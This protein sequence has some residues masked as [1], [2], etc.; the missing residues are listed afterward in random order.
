MKEGSSKKEAQAKKQLSRLLKSFSI[1]GVLNLLSDLFEEASRQAEA[2]NDRH[3]RDRCDEVRVAL[4]VLG[5]GADAVCAPA[6][7]LL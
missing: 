5:L 2:A 3:G 4:L 1:G 7:Y 6:R